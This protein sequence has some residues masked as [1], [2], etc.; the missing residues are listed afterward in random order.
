MLQIKSIGQYEGASLQCEV[1]FRATRLTH[2]E[3][4]L[5]I[6]ITIW[7]VSCVVGLLI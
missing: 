4:G 5:H 6:P 3:C 2:I 7:T 1:T